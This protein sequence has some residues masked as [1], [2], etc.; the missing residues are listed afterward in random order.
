[1]NLTFEEWFSLASR[2]FQLVCL[3]A[4][5]V[6]TKMH[7]WSCPR[8]TPHSLFWLVLSTHVCRCVCVRMWVHYVRRSLKECW[9]C[10]FSWSCT[11]PPIILIHDV[12][13]YSYNNYC[14]LAQVL[15]SLWGKPCRAVAY[16]L[17]LGEQSLLQTSELDCM[18]E[19][20]Q[21]S[22]PS[23]KALCIMVEKGPTTMMPEGLKL[24]R[25]EP[26]SDTNRRDL[27]LHGQMTV[28]S[29]P[30]GV[31]YFTSR[32]SSSEFITSCHGACINLWPLGIDHC[33]CTCL[34]CQYYTDFCSNQVCMGIY[35]KPGSTEGESFSIT[36]LLHGL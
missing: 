3:A 4:P 6:V 30:L 16:F 33:M 10:S 34:N 11:L 18:V 15:G 20:I 14:E 24:W 28:G 32:E 27:E 1:M 19:S 23:C 9:T 7:P 12:T 21:D 13:V 5:I 36:W 8:L 2:L 22:M 35:W 26:F 25:S 29:A 17:G 31:F